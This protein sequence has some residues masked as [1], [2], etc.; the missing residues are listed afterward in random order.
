MFCLPFPARAFLPVLPKGDLHN[1]ARFFYPWH[2]WDVPL[3]NFSLYRKQPLFVESPSLP[4]TPSRCLW[5]DPFE[6]KLTPPDLGRIHPP[7]SSSNFSVN[8]CGYPF[9]PSCP[10]F[11]A[12]SCYIL[13]KV[14]FQ[15]GSATNLFFPIKL[16]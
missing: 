15:R 9:P 13:K 14:F 16:F 1:Y 10:G 5:L 11:C 12:F 3:R 4:S 2:R 6:G 8:S 7:L